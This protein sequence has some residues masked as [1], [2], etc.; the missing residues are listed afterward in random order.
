MGNPTNGFV[1]LVLSVGVVCGNPNEMTGF[2]MSSDGFSGISEFSVVTVVGLTIAGNV[3]EGFV[4]PPKQNPP[5]RGT[6]SLAVLVVAGLTAWLVI[7][8]FSVDGTLNVTVRAGGVAAGATIDAVVIACVVMAVTVVTSFVNGFAS[9]CCVDKIAG[10][11]MSDEAAGG[12]MFGVAVV[13]SADFGA[14]IVSLFAGFTGA[15]S[16]VL[17]FTLSNGAF[18]TDVVVAVLN[19]T[20]VFVDRLADGGDD[21]TITFGSSFSVDFLRPTLSTS[22]LDSSLRKKLIIN[23]IFDF[24]PRFLLPLNRDDVFAFGVT[25]DTDKL[26]SSSS[27]LLRDRS[28]EA[29][30]LLLSLLNRVS[31]GVCDVCGR[32]TT[33]S[34]MD[35]M[36]GLI[37]SIGRCNGKSLL[38]VPTRLDSVDIFL[39]DAQSTVGFS[40]ESAV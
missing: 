20:V 3:N 6:D 29:K 39:T 9:L 19:V 28:F 30:I 40:L 33:L 35:F 23:C 4:S 24:C 14:S 15:T 36:T 22:S 1:V 17:V 5:S 11:V 16:M 18:Q 8:V 10:V 37:C 34:E 38:L 13:V 31:F 12:I 2:L 25:I 32:D 7:V 26:S 27:S 21:E